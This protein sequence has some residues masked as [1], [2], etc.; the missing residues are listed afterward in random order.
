M[1]FFPRIRLKMAKVEAICARLGRGV[2]KRID[3]NR[4]LLELLQREM[5]DF[6]ERHPWI[7]GWIKSQDEFLVELA[8]ATESEKMLAGQTSAFPRAWPGK[9]SEADR[10]PFH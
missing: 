3:E 2:F 1:I 8:K 7:E 5:P 10:P 4:E 9:R 6:V